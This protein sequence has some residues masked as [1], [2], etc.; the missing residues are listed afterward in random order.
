[1]VRGAFTWKNE[2]KGFKNRGLKKGG[3]S[4]LDNKAFLRA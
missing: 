1:M 2:G 4:Y 3:V